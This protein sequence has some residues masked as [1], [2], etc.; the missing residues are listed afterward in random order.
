[1][2]DVRTTSPIA[3]EVPPAAAREALGEARYDS[4][5]HAGPFEGGGMDADR[6]HVEDVAIHA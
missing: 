2:I 5:E 6:H 1:M 4:L 3:P